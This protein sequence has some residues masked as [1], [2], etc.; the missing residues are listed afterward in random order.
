MA[1]L[2]AL[3]DGIPKLFPTHTRKLVEM[4]NELRKQL[5]EAIGPHGVMLYPTYATSAPKHNYA[6]WTSL[7]M[8]FPFAYQGIMNVMQLPSTQVPLGLGPEGLPVGCQ[9]IG[10]HGNDH[11]TIGVA[12]ELERALG[13]WVPPKRWVEERDPTSPRR[14]EAEAAE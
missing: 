6:V 3:G 1:S 5:V 13:G 14:A 8:S 7:N 12:R 2:L 11:V 4:G 9:V 10:V